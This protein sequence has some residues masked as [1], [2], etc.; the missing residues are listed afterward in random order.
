MVK[1]TKIYL[2]KDILIF[3][4]K[5]SLFMRKIGRKSPEKRKSYFSERICRALDIEPDALPNSSLVE[6]RGRGAVSVSGGGKILTY[7][8]EEIRIAL[9]KGAVAI[10]GRHLICASFCAGKVRIEGRIKSVKFEDIDTLPRSYSEKRG[11]K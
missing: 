7:T 6:I 3:Y 4:E 9:K 2:L 11:A 5:E 10:H 8:D 1:Y